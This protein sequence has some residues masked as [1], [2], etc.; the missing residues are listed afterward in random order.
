MLSGLVNSFSILQLAITNTYLFMSHKYRAF[1][2][3]T[4]YLFLNSL[5]F[6]FTHLFKLLVKEEAKIGHPAA[7]LIFS[8]HFT[9]VTFPPPPNFCL[10]SLYCKYFCCHNPVY[11]QMLSVWV[12]LNPL[13]PLSGLSS[14]RNLQI[15]LF[16]FFP[17]PL[18]L[19]YW[20][21]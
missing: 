10:S 21:L 5:F 17:F 18:C 13:L 2:A 15:F 20:I 7:Q 12:N 14:L 9:W 6:S 11:T 4:H 19:L 1:P 8:A 3:L 16:T